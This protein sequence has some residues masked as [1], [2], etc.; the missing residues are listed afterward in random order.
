MHAEGVA[1]NQAMLLVFLYTN[2]EKSSPLQSIRREC[3]FSSS[4]ATQL[5]RVMRERGYIYFQYGKLSSGH[6]VPFFYLSPKGIA[7]AKKLCDHD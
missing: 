5:C 6:H 3:G 4:L 7:L 2:G 1:T